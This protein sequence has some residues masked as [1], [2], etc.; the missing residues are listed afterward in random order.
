METRQMKSDLRTLLLLL[1]RSFPRND[2]RH[3]L[4]QEIAKRYGMVELLS[5][6]V[7]VY[8]GGDG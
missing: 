6:R 2:E 5:D 7:G 1:L 8:M 4:A 3:A